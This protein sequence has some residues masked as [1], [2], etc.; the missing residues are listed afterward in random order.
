M[1]FGACIDDMNRVIHDLVVATD[2]DDLTAE[3]LA[4]LVALI[5]EAHALREKLQAVAST[6]S[7]GKIRI[8]RLPPETT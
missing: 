5:E 4:E 3:S 6:I 1:T 2:R 8:S 7:T